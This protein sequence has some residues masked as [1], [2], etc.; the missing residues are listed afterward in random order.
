[1]YCQHLY[2]L[3]I[4]IEALSIDSDRFIEELSIRNLGT[5]V[6][7]MTVYLKLSFHRR[8]GYKG[9][10]FSVAENWLRM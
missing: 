3:R 2:P 7:F 5:S 8:Y 9:G 4:I 6:R 10:D 1:M